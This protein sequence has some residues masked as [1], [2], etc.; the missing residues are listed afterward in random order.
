MA[1]GTLPSS[2]PSLD[3]IEIKDFVLGDQNELTIGFFGGTMVFRSIGSGHIDYKF[4]SKIEYRDEQ[5]D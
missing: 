3:Y 2:S 4:K 5:E 1:N